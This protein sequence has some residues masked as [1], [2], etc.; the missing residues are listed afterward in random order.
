MKIPLQVTFR[1]MSRSDAI[2]ARINDKLSKLDSVYTRITACRIAVEKLQRKHQNGNLFGVRIDITM[3]GK[4]FTVNRQENTD[5]YVAVRDAFD[6]V[7]R[8]LDG[9]RQ[10]QRGVVKSHT[11]PAAGRIAR[12]FYDSGYGFIAA[13]NDRDVYFHENSVLDGIDFKELRPGTEVT[14]IEEQGS[15]GPQAARVSLSKR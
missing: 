4:E 13:A 14:F 11:V 7:S 2:E 10:Q 8:L 6:A 3:P 5:V 9:Y 15:E 12:V 1:N